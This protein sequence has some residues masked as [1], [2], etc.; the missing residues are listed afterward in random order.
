MQVA[1]SIDSTR[2]VW[3]E[4][5]DQKMWDKRDIWRYLSTILPP[6]AKIGRKGEGYLNMKMISRLVT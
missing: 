4:T 6:G 1:D 5:E 3:T 2:K